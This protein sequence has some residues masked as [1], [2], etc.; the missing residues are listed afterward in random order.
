MKKLISCIQLNGKKHL[1]ENIFLKIAKNLQKCSNKN[2]KNSINLALIFSMPVFKTDILTNNN[3][4]FSVLYKNESRTF[5]SIKFLFQ[6]IKKKKHSNIL[7]KSFYKEIILI[8]KNN[9]FVLVTKKKLQESVFLKKHF[10]T[11]YRWR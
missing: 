7:Y 5:L 8:L 6:I 11:Y 9:S 3:N 1:S 2:F 4:N 10:F